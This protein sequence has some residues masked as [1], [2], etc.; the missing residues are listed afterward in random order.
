MINSFAKFAAILT[1]GSSIFSLPAFTSPLT[2]DTLNSDSIQQSEFQQTNCRESTSLD[3]HFQDI[4]YTHAYTI[5]ES[6]SIRNQLNDFLGVK[7]LFNRKIKNEP[8]FPDQRIQRDSAL[9]WETYN[10]LVKLQYSPISKYTDDIPNGYNSSLL[11]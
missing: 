2:C 11:N 6:N 1:F 4:F 5:P 9:L 7:N 8:G 3:E 10:D